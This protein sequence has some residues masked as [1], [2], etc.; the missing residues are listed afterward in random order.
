MDDR[1]TGSILIFFGLLIAG[2]G[3]TMRNI[4]LAVFYIIGFLM[5]FVG[6]GFLIKYRKAKL[7]EA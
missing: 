7:Q 4:F 6:L 2:L 5:A 3:G 1:I